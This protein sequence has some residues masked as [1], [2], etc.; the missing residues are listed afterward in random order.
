MS[1]EKHPTLNTAVLVYPM[2]PNFGF[3][4]YVL[5]KACCNIKLAHDDLKMWKCI[6]DVVEE[7]KVTEQSAW[8]F[9]VSLISALNSYKEVVWLA[10]ERMGNNWSCSERW[11]VRLSW[12]SSGWTEM[13]PVWDENWRG[14][15]RG[16]C[17]R[18]NVALLLLS[19]MPESP[20]ISNTR[21]PQLL[22][23]K[24]SDMTTLNASISRCLGGWG[25]L[26]GRLW[27]WKRWDLPC[28]G[29]AGLNTRKPG[30][31]AASRQCRWTIGS[32]LLEGAWDEDL[33][34]GC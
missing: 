34:T 13:N 28:V 9:G 12:R 30:V 32:P 21:V 25:V 7:I 11:L 18:T 3:Y 1:F 4:I 2:L 22:K 15:W 17:S 8:W 24:Q 23:S 29:A 26:A 20:S 10:R 14:N 31:L 33:C 16:S 5:W 19:T 27:S 6:S